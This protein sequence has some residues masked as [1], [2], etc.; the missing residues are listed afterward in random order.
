M[1][2]SRVRKPFFRSAGR[3]SGFSSDSARESPM[4]TAPACPPTPPPFTCALHFHLVVHLRELQRLD[5]RRVP[6]HV[7][8]IVVHRPAIHGETRR[9]R[10]DVDA[11]HRFAAASRAVK[12]LCA[13]LRT[14]SLMNSTFLLTSV[15][16]PRIEI[17]P[18]AADFSAQTNLRYRCKRSTRLQCEGLRLLSGVAGQRF[19]SGIDTQ[20]LR[21]T[22]SQL[23]LRQ[24][25]QHRF[26][27][28]FFRTP[29]HAALES[30]LPSTHPDIRCGGGR[31]SGRSCF[32]SA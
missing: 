12:L 28:H 26:A 13:A 19:T 15:I 31:S 5:R 11:R 20:L 10:L 29:L 9:A 7:A 27:H 14:N 23:V 21:A 24:H 17:A 1:R 2:E 16:L 6:R 22:R 32:R 4:R 25:S 18:R 3:S 30:E 8:E